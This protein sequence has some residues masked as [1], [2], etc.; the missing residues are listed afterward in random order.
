MIRA[1]LLSGTLVLAA[2]GSAQAQRLTLP[3]GEWGLQGAKGP[4]CN[5][6][7]LK[8][9]KGQVIKRLGGGEGRCPI[10]KIKKEG[11]YLMVEVKCVYDKS[12]PAE[13][14][15][16]GDDDDDSFSLIVKSPTLILFNNT[17]HGLCRSAAEMGR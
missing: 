3:V 16:E 7:F 8:I 14:L 9:E 17:P 11:K 1:A 10:K 6:A 4:D 15:I 13:H 2:F 12:I 5:P